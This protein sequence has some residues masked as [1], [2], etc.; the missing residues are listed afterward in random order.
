MKYPLLMAM[1]IR[2]HDDELNLGDKMHALYECDGTMHAIYDHD[3]QMPALNQ[4]C[5]YLIT[6][7][8]QLLVLYDHNI[9]PHTF[10]IHAFYD[11]ADKKSSLNPC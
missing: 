8:I 7:I 11:H 2:Y 1:K 10:M 3:D 6:I 9:K 5:R 4:N